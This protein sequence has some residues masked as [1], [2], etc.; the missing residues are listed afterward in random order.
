MKRLRS[1]IIWPGFL[2]LLIAA[3]VTLDVTMI[4]V[5]STS[6]TVQRG[7]RVVQPTPR[8]VVTETAPT[9]APLPPRETE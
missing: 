8:T 6:P 3:V 2:I 9:P 5:S 7:R 4:I 1:L